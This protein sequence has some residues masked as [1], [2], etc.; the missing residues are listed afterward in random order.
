MKL[1]RARVVN[2]RSID[3]SSWVN[4]DDVTA[5]VGKNESGKTAFLQAIRKINSI[6]GDEDGFTIRDYPRKG[7]IKYKK[8]HEQNPCEVAQAEFELTPEEVGE[9]EANFGNG[10][11]ASNKVIVTKNYK[12]DRAW[13]IE[14]SESSSNSPNTNTFTQPSNPTP[15][16]FQNPVQN[17]EPSISVSEKIAEQFMEKWLPKF[18][19]FDNYSLM[20]GKISINELRERS[21]NGGPLDDADRT[22]LSLLTLSGVSLEDLEKDLGY[23]DIKVELESASITITD[24]IFEYWQQNRQL[25]VEFDVSQADPRD[26]APLNEGKILHVRIE[27]ARHRV[28]V[29]FDERSKGFVWFFS[30]LSYFSHLEETE[31]GDLIILLDEP[32]TALHA[33]AQKDF[34]RFMDER[35]SPRCQ[36]LYSTHSPFMIDLDKLHRIRLVQ[37]MDGV[38]TV[39]SDDAV[40]NDRETVFPLQ[41]ALGYQMAQTLFLAPHCLMVNSPSDLIYLQVLGDMVTEVSGVRIDPRW[42]IIPVGSTDNLSTFVT[43]LGDNYVSVAVMMDLTPTNKEKIEAINKKN[44]SEGENPVKWVQ[45]TRVRDAD[46]EDLFDPKVY[47]ELVNLSYATQLD[48]PLT[49]RTIT[50]SNPRIVERLKAY[51]SR[52]GIAG[53]VF[54]RYVPASYL[55]ENFDSFKGNLSE[56]TL[57]KI[58]TLVER[59]NSLIVDNDL[60]NVKEMSGRD[61]SWKSSVGPGKDNTVN[62][63]TLN[64]DSTEPATPI[65]S[66][67]VQTQF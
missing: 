19:Y 42:V 5:L 37:D 11:L 8:I 36:V 43:L 32:G 28:T 60:L 62:I 23:E 7:Y 20:R 18:V 16:S 6:S 48:E 58:Q 49:M 45:V 46:I 50:D 34:L 26:P 57:E 15:T 44:E 41:M 51:F 13:K 39:I 4:I 40:H 12:N 63:G 2:Y 14:L 53:G 55:L 33:M 54:D 22:F 10:V 31:S 65:G 61:K 21:E 27:N 3:D 9:I 29:S 24:E 17:I 38:G 52:M 66:L 67:P 30:F 59:I 1:T 25:K 64:I 35:L 56:D 47:L